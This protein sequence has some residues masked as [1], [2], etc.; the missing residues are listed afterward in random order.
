MCQ[1][2]NLSPLFF[3]YF[4]ATVH[5]FWYIIGKS[6]SNFNKILY[7]F[8]INPEDL[9]ASHATITSKD[10]LDLWKAV[11]IV[12]ELKRCW[13]CK[14]LYQSKL[15]PDFCSIFCFSRILPLSEKSI[16]LA[17]PG[18]L[19]VSAL[20][21]TNFDVRVRN[22]GISLALAFV[23]TCPKHGS[24]TTGRGCLLL[25]LV[26][27]ASPA[28]KGSLEEYLLCILILYLTFFEDCILK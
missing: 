6:E 15:K 19:H 5:C 2:P 17:S 7:I 22:K 28:K 18:V 8:D 11:L 25:F 4:P 21:W 1:G 20:V 24:K 3:I 23:C 27:L 13:S 10:I 26:F 16:T 9:V 12:W 14:Y